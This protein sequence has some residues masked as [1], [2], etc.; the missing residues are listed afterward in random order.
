[1]VPKEFCA[2][3]RR[4]AP[5]PESPTYADWEVIEDEQGCSL[6]VCPGCLTPEE[7]AGV[8]DNAVD[9]EQ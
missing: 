1:M 3:C 5:H 6:L 7:E 9:F 4:E 8:T 2:R